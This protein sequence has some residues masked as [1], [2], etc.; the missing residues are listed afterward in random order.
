M[1]FPMILLQ[2]A[3]WIDPGY[4]WFLLGVIFLAGIGTTVL[5]LVSVVACIQRRTVRFLLVTLALAALV[6]RTIVGFGTMLGF[7]PMTIHHLLSHS[8]DFLIAII[9]LYGVYQSGPDMQTLSVD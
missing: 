3:N 2:G 4:S 7:V 1:D 9:I 5:F 6:I 8:L